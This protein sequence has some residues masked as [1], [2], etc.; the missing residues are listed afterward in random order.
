MKN[1][2]TLQ[3]PRTVLAFTTIVSSWLLMQAIHESGHAICAVLTGGS[4][5]RIV[6]VS[7][8][9]S[10]TDLIQNPRP[11]IVCWAG[12]IMGVA[13]PV[14]IWLLARQIGWTGA[15]WLRFLA[16][17][18]LIA[19]GA[20]IGVGAFTQDG[21]SGDLIREG[22]PVWLLSIFGMSTTLVGLLL[23][24]RLGEQF[25]FG[26]NGRLIS[27]KPAIFSLFITATIVVVEWIFAAA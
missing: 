18:C 5:R 1:M 14:A 22:S 24:H 2:A 16:G 12:P 15:F 11:L 23:W 20:Y 25:G 21:D 10:R 26:A 3:F 13:A 19:N 4:V 6:L 9:F 27:W 8:E 7:W 17:F